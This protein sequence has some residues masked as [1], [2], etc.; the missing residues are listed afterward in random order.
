M[1]TRLFVSCITNPAVPRLTIFFASFPQVR[2][3]SLYNKRTLYSA[4][5][6]RKYKTYPAD[7]HWDKTV[8]IA[9][10]RIPRLSIKMKSGSRTILA[11]APITTEIIP[12]VAYP[13]ALMNG[14][15]PVAIMEGKVPIR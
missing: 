13:C 6:E 10:P 11:M 8:A 1:L 7:K 5:F 15:I 2:I 14:F 12:V 3:S 9:A 4:F